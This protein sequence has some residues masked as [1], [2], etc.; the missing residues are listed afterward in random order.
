MGI[1]KNDC[2]GNRQCLYG[3]SSVAQLNECGKGCACSAATYSVNG[4]QRAACALNNTSSRVAKRAFYARFYGTCVPKM[5]SNTPNDHDTSSDTQPSR[6]SP[7]LAE[8]PFVTFTTLAEP[9]FS[10]ANDN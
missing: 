7:G 3:C 8:L 4:T 9:G 1:C 10:H 2:Q 6:N 5:T